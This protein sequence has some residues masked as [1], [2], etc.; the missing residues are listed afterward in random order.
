MSIAIN[1][2]FLKV[3]IL[4]KNLVASSANGAKIQIP[5]IFNRNLQLLLSLGINIMATRIRLR[6]IYNV[7]KLQKLKKRPTI[8]TERKTLKVKYILDSILAIFTYLFVLPRNLMHS[9]GNSIFFI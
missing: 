6:R 8:D 4:Q 9:E 7:I 5:T 1:Y 2:F 3:I